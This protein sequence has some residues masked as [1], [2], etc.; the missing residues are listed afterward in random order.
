MSRSGGYMG[1]GFAIP[2]NLARQI[3]D[4]LI[5]KG[6][7]Q[8]GWLGVSIQDLNPELA[9]QFGIGNGKG[10]LITEIFPGTPAAAAGLAPGDVIISVGGRAVADSTSLRNTVANLEPGARV[11]VEVIRDGEDKTFSLTLGER[12]GK[13]ELASAGRGPVP[14]TM[15]KAKAAGMSVSNLTPELA[16]QLGIKSD[17]SGVVVTDVEPGSRADRAEVQVGDVIFKINR[18]TVKDV[19]DFNRAIREAGDSPILIHLRRDNGNLFLVVP[20]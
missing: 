14:E 11:D 15:G 20:K 8:R 19:S 18:Q 4:E 17:V 16:D 5:S 12:P 13:D 2:V 10:A 9:R 6:S 1:I 3:M 7:V